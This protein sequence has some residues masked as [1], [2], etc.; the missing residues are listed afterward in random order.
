ML[1]TIRASNQAL[2]RQIAQGQP[3]AAG[4]A[5]PRMRGYEFILLLKKLPEFEAVPAVA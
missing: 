2:R 3:S 5:W 4:L 1:L